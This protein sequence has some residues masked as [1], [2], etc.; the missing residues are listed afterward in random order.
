MEHPVYVNAMDEKQLELYCELSNHPTSSDDLTRLVSLVLMPL[1]CILGILGASICVIV[2]TR[3]QMRSSLNIYLAGLSAFDLILLIMSLLIYPAMNICVL[4][5]NRGQTCHFFWRSSLVTYPISL[6]AQTAS[7]WTCVAITVDRFLAVKYPLHMRVWCTP[8]C[9]MVVLGCIA[10]ISVVYKLPSVF[11]LGLDECGRLMT[12][13]LRKHP[14][15]IIFY[16]SYGNLLL[17]LMIPWIVIIVLNVIIVKAVHAAYRLR[18]ELCLN[19]PIED[20]NRCTKMATVTIVAFIL[21][22]SLSGI[23]NVIEG[24]DLDVPGHRYRIPL[25]NLLV[26]VNS[27]SNILIYSIFGQR[28]RKL[29]VELF[30]CKGYYSP[31]RNSGEHKTY[32]APENSTRR[33]SS[34]YVMVDNSRRPS[35]AYIGLLAVE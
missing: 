31:N 29:C 28:F 27:A 14:L 12:T 13:Q 9:A 20:E 21:L 16:I 10:M 34:T 17:L 6:I 8:R 5:G 4:Q 3:K 11:E 24:F 7:V 33:A 18:R 30:L 35:N 22:N 23:N 32:L 25:G 1:T 15:Y 19:Q 26:C 2:F